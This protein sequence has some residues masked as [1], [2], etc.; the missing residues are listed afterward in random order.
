MGSV[1]VLNS[2]SAGLGDDA[3]DWPSPNVRANCSTSRKPATNMIR[4]V[5]L[6]VFRL[7]CLVLLLGSNEDDASCF[8]DNTIIQICKNGKLAER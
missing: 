4:L 1:N 8:Q 6:N 7:L 3:T 2:D 5:Q